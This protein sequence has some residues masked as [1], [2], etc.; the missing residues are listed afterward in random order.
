[1]SR[2]RGRRS[3]VVV[4][5]LGLA[6]VAVVVGLNLAG[7]GGDDGPRQGPEL[8]TAAV[9]QR[10]L[11]EYLEITG[12]LDYAESV[13]LAAQSRGVLLHLAPEG[14]V[15]RRGELLYE[16]VS[17]TTEA[18]TA[19]VLARLASARNSLV[20]AQEQLS[21]AVAGA[22]EADIAGA[23]ASVSDAREARDHLLEPPT[24]A[25][26][27]SAEAA[28][29]NAA[30][31]LD[32]LLAPSAADLDEARSRLSAARSDLTDLLAGASQA[33]VD[34]ARAAVLAAESDLSD[35]LAGASQADVDSARAAVL[36]AESDLSDLLAG[37]SEAEIAAARAAVLV[38]EENF[39]DYFYYSVSH[40]ERAAR[41]ADLA[42]ARE[43]LAELLAG[44]SE[45]D[46]DAA[47]AQVLVAREALADLLAGASE[48]D[49]DAAEAQVLVAR[50]A[51]ADL[52]AGVSEADLETA[53]A[54]VQAAAEAVETLE[55]PTE[56]A[57]L[58]ARSDFAGAQEA[59]D[60]LMDGP[61]EAEIDL[62]EAAVLAAEE[63]LEDLLAGYSAA[64]IEALE[65]SVDSAEAA[66]AS[67]E[68]DLD[69]LD[70]GRSQ[71][72]VM[73]GRIPV[74]R[75][76]SLGIQ[77]EDVRQLQQNL[78]ELGYGDPGK[79][80]ADGVFDDATAA[81]VLAWQEAT[82]RDPDGTVD[83]ADVLFVTGP[84]Q[85]GAW[86]Q[87]V[88]LGQETAPGAALAALTVIQAPADGGSEMATT[89]QVLA[90]LPLSDRD[91]VSEGIEVNV[92]L[93]DSTDIAGTVTAISPFPVLD[94]QTGDS[95]VEIT[96]LLAQPAADAWIGATVDVE[97]TETLIE[98]ALVVPATA[99]LALV[100]GGYAVEVLDADGA[101]R[102]V[103]VETGLFVDGDVE[104]Q[105]G[106]L[107]PGVRVVVPR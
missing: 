104:V 107:A 90:N 63:A 73:Y 12:T 95:T 52:L 44:A 21:D 45:A 14:S 29:E 98:D 88:E 11:A 1:M 72:V 74:F 16:T 86:T 47:E 96:I 82:G 78:I 30:E 89:Q 69:A 87:G 35:L 42:L 39:D 97:I 94:A 103:G 76:M 31:A 99:L 46:V 51:L 53:E 19:D 83:G 25:E 4:I 6:A 106:A 68:A 9:E 10:A 79:L 37:A 77:G 33:D 59:L 100:E 50:E 18:E 75:T 36:A 40:P 7:T 66:V 5:G 15:V 80:E 3:L 65:A 71:R 84:V 55:N 26:I 2:A 48:A 49:V 93:P 64:E 34:S 43:A 56:G 67:A 58:A 13:T 22:T 85:V 105:S 101:V 62:A 17:E 57:R 81:V 91:L 24:K 38:A 60:D 41:E 54:A 61:T 8:T 20:T 70:A 92:E 102:L 23:R 32:T 28:V 27:V